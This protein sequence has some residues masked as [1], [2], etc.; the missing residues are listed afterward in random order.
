[1]SVV[2]GITSKSVVEKKQKLLDKFDICVESVKEL[3]RD[4][5]KNRNN[6]DSE[7]VNGDLLLIIEDIK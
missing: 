6:L 3:I 2:T 1:M 5:K 7:V 4:N